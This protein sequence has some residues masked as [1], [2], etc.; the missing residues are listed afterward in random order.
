MTPTPSLSFP[1]EHANLPWLRR[2]FF[3]SGKAT[4]EGLVLRHDF[5]DVL[6]LRLHVSLHG[7]PTN[8][9]TDYY[10]QIEEVPR[11]TSLLEMLSAVLQAANTKAASVGGVPR[12]EYQ[13]QETIDEQRAAE[14]RVHEG[15]SKYERRV[16]ESFKAQQFPF[17]VAADVTHRNG[18]ML[19]M[20][21]A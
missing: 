16:R 17:A 18:P 6:T 20:P 4:R 5:E 3:S 13:Q 8:V 11:I 12:S 2:Q 15:S 1:Q 14:A 10:V 21:A 19:V 7:A 9:A